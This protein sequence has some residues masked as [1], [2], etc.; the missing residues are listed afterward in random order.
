MPSMTIRGLSAQL[1]REL[2]ARARASR[3]SLNAQVLAWLDE[4]RQREQ[5]QGDAAELLREIDRHVQ[6]TRRRRQSD[7][8]GLIRRMRNAR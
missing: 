1:L 3:R 8:T 2:R 6:K 5:A 4:A 7:S